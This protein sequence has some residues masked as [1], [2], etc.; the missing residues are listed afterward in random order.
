MR[1]FE[2]QDAVPLF[3]CPAK[4]NTERVLLVNTAENA[5]STLPS[6]TRFRLA[7]LKHNSCL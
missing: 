7:S 3:D 1:A 6:R 2:F 5:P 4:M